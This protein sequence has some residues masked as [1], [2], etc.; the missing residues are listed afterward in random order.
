M[1]PPTE[2]ECP[3]MAHLGH[4]VRRVARLLK[5]QEQTLESRHTVAFVNLR[6]R[7]L[8]TGSP[9]SIS[10]W[11]GTKTGAVSGRWAI[12]ASVATVSI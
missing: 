10:R 6:P 5:P 7:R 11:D 9:V 4:Y 8:S 12:C 1:P 3:F 2:G